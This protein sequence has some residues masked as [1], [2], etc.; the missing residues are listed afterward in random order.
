MEVH[1]LLSVYSKGCRENGNDFK[2]MGTVLPDWRLSIMPKE[3]TNYARIM[4][5][6]KFS[7]Y[8]I[9]MNYT[10]YDIIRLSQIFVKYARYYASSS[11]FQRGSMIFSISC[12]WGSNNCNGA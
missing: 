11:I 2:P 1:I 12:N 10:E 5:E 7:N 8:T 6:F 4:P 3:L 9:I